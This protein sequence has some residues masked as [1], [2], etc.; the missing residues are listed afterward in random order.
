MIDSPLPKNE[1]I[2][3][4]IGNKKIKILHLSNKGTPLYK[5]LLQ[6]MIAAYSKE[7]GNSCASSQ[8]SNFQK[9]VCK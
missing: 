8:L 6:E 3:Y 7:I 5:K 2:H 9:W 4:N 1:G